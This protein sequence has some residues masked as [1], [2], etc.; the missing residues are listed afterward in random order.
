MAFL[1]LLA[2]TIGDAALLLVLLDPEER[3]ELRA[4]RS[5]EG[6]GGEFLERKSAK[7][8]KFGA[9]GQQEEGLRGKQEEEICCCE[10]ARRKKF[11]F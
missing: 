10:I 2:R 1:H 9:M 8:R 5:G 3:A 4:D 11:G 7:A 6:F